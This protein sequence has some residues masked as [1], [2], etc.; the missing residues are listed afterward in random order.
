MFM[1]EQR[2]KGLTVVAPMLNARMSVM[3]VMV[4]ETPALFRAWPMRCGTGR[5]FSFGDNVFKDCTSYKNIIE[6]NDNNKAYMGHI[7]YIPQIIY[8][9]YDEHV[10]D[11]DSK[12]QKR[13]YGVDWSK[14]QPSIRTQ[15]VRR[16]YA[17]PN[18]RNSDE[19]Q[20][21]LRN[22]IYI[23]IYI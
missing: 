19:R 13:K 12:Q 11:A 3:E 16:K 5:F 7:S 9:D 15:P 4:I 6:F 23:Y 2:D 20:H 21:Y 22:K 17:Q 18:V 1:F 14:E 10:I 8:L